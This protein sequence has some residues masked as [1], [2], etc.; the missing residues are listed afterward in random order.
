[1][2]SWADWV[3]RSDAKLVPGVREYIDL[4]INEF[5]RLMSLH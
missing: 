3:N 2:E 1:M 5:K 4:V